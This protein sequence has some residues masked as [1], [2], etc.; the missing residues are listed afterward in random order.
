M[1]KAKG[2]WQREAL[3]D[4]KDSG[5]PLSL[6]GLTEYWN[7]IDDMIEHRYGEGGCAEGRKHLRSLSRAC[8]S[9]M[10]RAIKDLGNE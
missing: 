8:A 4:M 9:M 6:D 1:L 2:G 3:R 10:D 5:I 7:L